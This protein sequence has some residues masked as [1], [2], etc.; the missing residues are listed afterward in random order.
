[1]H[2]LKISKLQVENFRN[3]KPFIIE[4]NE[5]INCIIGSNGN[6]KTN[7]LEAVYYL[8]KRKSFRKNT[9]FP[10]I[11]GV[12][13]E[14]MEIL[15][16]AVF[17]SG[18]S[19]QTYISGK[20]KNDS[21]NWLM[22]NESTKKKLKVPLILI[23]PFDAFLFYTNSS[24]RREWFDY[25]ISQISD[26]YSKNNRKFEKLIKFRNQLIFSKPYKFKEQIEAIDSEI[27]ILSVI[28]TEQRIQFLNEM[29]Q[30]FE[31]I[32][33]KIFDQNNQLKVVLDSKLIG[34]SS[35][36]IYYSMQNELSKDIETGK[37]N[38][39]AHLDN[40]VIVFNNF[41]S[42]EFCSLGQQK[43]CFISLQFAYINLFR[44]KFTFYPIVLID[45]ISGELDK[46]RW[47]KLIEFLRESSFQILITT[48]NEEFMNELKRTTNVKILNVDSGKVI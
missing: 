7:I 6:G 40:Y 8:I 34:W 32:F 5:G 29:N 16:S 1:M 11:I 3:L 37:T 19:L 36:K 47:G 24:F 15:F 17:T 43:I 35:E 31:A 38:Y 2:G 44:Y 48:A 14:Q 9:S 21:Q 12:D 27:S 26:G 45:D 39:A 33:C 30:Y 28:L 20:V 23:N 46:N 13:S 22:N 4:F 25:A 42:S 18:E 41:N 10:Q